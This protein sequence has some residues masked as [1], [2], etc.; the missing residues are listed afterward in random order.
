MLCQI[1]FCNAIFYSNKS[2]PSPCSSRPTCVSQSYRYSEAHSYTQLVSCSREQRS[3]DWLHPTVPTKYVKNNAASGNT[4]SKQLVNS[5]SCHQETL[6]CLIPPGRF[7]SEPKPIEQRSWI[8][9]LQE[10]VICVYVLCNA[11]WQLIVQLER[12]L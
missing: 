3:S 9:L 1:Q 5:V 11:C 4:S 12:Q 7:W 6:L 10:S 8:R 2:L